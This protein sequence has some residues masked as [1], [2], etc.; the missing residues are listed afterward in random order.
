MGR[1]KTKTSR[2]LFGSAMH[3]LRKIRKAFSDSPG[4]GQA[5]ILREKLRHAIFELKAADKKLGEVI[6]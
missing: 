2:F 5:K 3:E 6:E 1:K 4:Y